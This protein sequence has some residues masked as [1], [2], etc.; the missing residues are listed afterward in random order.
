MLG[1]WNQLPM[2]FQSFIISTAAGITTKL[3]PPG[4]KKDDIKEPLQD[5]I[6]TGITGF[7]KCFYEKGIKV[8]S[9]RKIL[10]ST[11]LKALFIELAKDESLAGK[12]KYKREVINAI[13]VTGTDVL[14]IK[15]FKLQV[16]LTAF[17][18]GFKSKAKY[19][20]KLLS[21]L[22]HEIFKQKS[23][24]LKSI[25]ENLKKVRKSIEKSKPNLPALKKKY[26][27]F[28]KE[29]YSQMSFKGLSE[30]KLISFP[31]EK[32]YTK[33]TFEKEIPYNPKEYLKM[34]EEVERQEIIREGREREEIKLSNIL[35]AQY[36][37]ITGDPGAGKSTLLKYIALAYVDKKVKERLGFRGGFLPI[38]FPVAAYAE[39]RKK[40]GPVGYSIS[41]F[42]PE[43]FTGK[44][45]PDLSLL[46]SK[47]L[48]QGTALVLIDGLDEVTDEAER[49]NMVEDIRSYIIDDK[50]AQNKFIITCRTASYTKAARF[51]PVGGTEFS[52]F[53]VLPFDLEHIKVFLFNWY[54]CY[55]RDINERVKTFEAEAN[56]DLRTMMS[57]INNDKNI[58]SI[59]TNPLMLTI[60][61]LIEH[62]GGELPKNRADLY[63]KCLRML[64]GSWENLRSMHEAERPDFKLG[65]RKI[66]EDFIVA[67]L[68]PIAYE[69]H[70]RSAPDIEYDDLK[71]RLAKML[72]IRNKELLYSREQADDFIQIMKERSGIL[73]EASPGVYGF[74]HLTFKEYLSSRVLTDIS[75]DRIAQLD[76]R[77]F[78]P[79]WKEVVLLTASSLK[80]RDATEFIKTI[81][82]RNDD[83]FQNLILAGECA[84]N[85]DRDRID[86]VFYDDIIN[87]MLKVV[88]SDSSIQDKV[89]VAETLGWLGDTRKLDLF[90]KIDG[91]EYD[92]EKLGKK[93]IETF[94]IGQYPVTNGWYE[95]FVRDS[96]YQKKEF[97]SK[98]GQKWL[99]HT[100]QE[101]PRYLDERKWRCPNTPVVGVTWYE[102][103]AF[104]KWLTV[105]RN[106]EYIYRLPTEE[107]WQAAAAG[108]GG[109]EYPWGDWEEKVCN[110]SEAKIG[111][112]SPV[113]IFAKGRT[114]ETEIYD[115]GGNVWEWTATN[116]YTGKKQEMFSYYQEWELYD[117]NKQR[118]VLRGGSWV[119]YHGDARCANRD[120]GGP[121]LG[122]SNVGFRC[123][124][125]KK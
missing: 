11:E 47:A 92:L 34:K 72:D 81:F 74:M 103:D 64:A 30:G 1:F 68:G 88:E 18:N 111:K 43:Y 27:H 75:D 29:K 38:I 87:T 113:G 33:L 96:G 107:E 51:E 108:L 56:K 7:I 90:I 14:N 36:S 40:E 49:K 91:G 10:T 116:Y 21:Y 15:G 125:T 28:L 35:D 2:D 70:E 17:I 119:D 105:F 80:K 76:D 120:R 118:T 73:Q 100:K 13:N 71:D 112:T 104:T 109:R 62:E 46:F 8:H 114:P 9:I 85:T 82:K 57:V 102:A 77:L 67:F 65:D 42:I 12:T 32:I 86:D 117:K 6:R 4:K 26:F 44:N 101:Q 5:A 78:T 41:R 24:A 66:S 45:L 99:K 58:H 122:S 37:V 79:E 110:T 123:A 98:E 61:A 69:M 83:H 50:H 95:K 106:D 31:L 48:N 52:H 54:C 53:N 124:R 19:N 60:L 25:D 3:L 23:E 89:A 115:L 121:G 63:G 55:E 16:A 97:W 59:A 20:S 93:T 39:A 84:I 94:W 22:N